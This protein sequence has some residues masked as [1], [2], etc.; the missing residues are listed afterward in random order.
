VLRFS[1]NISILFTDVPFLERFSRAS[2]A[3]FRAVEFWWPTDVAAESLIEAAHESDCQVVLFNLDAG[4]MAGGERGLLSNPQHQDHF[5]ANAIEALELAARLKCPRV[6]APV[7]LRVPALDRAKQLGLAQ[8]NL[9][10]VA[11]LA[12]KRGIEILVEPLNPFDNGPCL[13]TTTQ[14]ATALIDAVHRDNVRVQYDVYHAHRME[15]NLVQ[16]IRRLRG[17]IGHIQ[18]ADSPGRGEP[19]TGEIDYG[20]I[21]TTID[22]V[23]YSGYIGLEYRPTT[24]TTERSFEWLPENRRYDN[25]APDRLR[26][27]GQLN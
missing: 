15:G 4:D 18:I 23:G 19:G 21:L 3:G 13:I 26:L 22:A 17:R 14:E 20:T 9:A 25:V 16:T 7:G 6:H 5:Q 27:F 24:E 12:H 10:W 2:V 11:D 1:A 8:R